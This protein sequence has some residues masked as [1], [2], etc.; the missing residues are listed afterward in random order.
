MTEIVFVSNVHVRMSTGRPGTR[1]ID[2]VK[3]VVPYSKNVF[4]CG[5]MDDHP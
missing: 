1:W 2:R 5:P 4:A 3:G